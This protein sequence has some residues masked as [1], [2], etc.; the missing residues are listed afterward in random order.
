MH[1]LNDYTDSQRCRY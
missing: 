1:E